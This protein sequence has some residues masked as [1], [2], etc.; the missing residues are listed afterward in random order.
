MALLLS[1]KVCLLYNID[2]LQKRVYNLLYN[3]KINIINFIKI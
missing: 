1:K 2:I 3:Y